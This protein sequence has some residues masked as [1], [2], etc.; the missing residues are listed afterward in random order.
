MLACGPLMIRHLSMRTPLA[1]L[2][3][4]EMAG[5]PFA[6]LLKQRIIFLGGEVSDFSADA[7]VSQ[8]LLL[9]AQDHTKASACV[10][11]DTVVVMRQVLAFSTT[12]SLERLPLLTNN[13]NTHSRLI[14]RTSSCS[15]T[16]PAAR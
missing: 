3:S 5:D 7:I 4:Q 9:D 16:R 8:L 14:R 2:R 13:T 15:S 10:H 12:K 1:T 11:V 6:L